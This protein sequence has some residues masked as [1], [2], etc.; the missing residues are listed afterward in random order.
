M[1]RSMTGFAT[2][3]REAGSDRVNVT[4]KSVNHRFLDIALRSP[5]RLASLEPRLRTIVQ[6]RLVRGRVEITVGVDSTALPSR[7]VRLD[8]DLLGRVAE[9]LEA[10][11]ARG[12]VSGTMTASDLLR[13]PDVL[14]VSDDS[15]AT[16][17]DGL[18]DSLTR[19]V[20]DV[21]A[22]TLV[23][24]VAMRDTEG[25][26]LGADLTARLATIRD[27][28][29]AIR[30]EAIAGQAALEARLRARLAALG[31]DVQ[32]E[33]SALAQEIVRFVARSDIDEE[34][35]RLESHLEHW[36]TLADSAEPCG[37]KLDF[38]VQEMNREVNTIG[39]KTESVRATELV[40][41]AK[42][43]LERIREQVQNVE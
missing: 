17:V 38:L 35:V 10:A 25:R 18:S 12:W 13:I 36:R 11:R 29:Q 22:D 5:Q 1:I 26:L 40:I 37:R 7:S 23:A 30:T 15:R 2:G 24:L 43:E 19:L 16:A 9:A 21:L 28:V 32:G 31:P 33:P 14:Q 20:E 41:A 6:Q 27:L 42:A 3:G 39:S 34:V 4:I 8:E